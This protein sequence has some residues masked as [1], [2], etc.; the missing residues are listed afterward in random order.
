LKKTWMLLFFMAFLEFA[1][2]LSL[3]E[4]PGLIPPVYADPQD[5]PKTP[6]AEKIL[7]DRGLGTQEIP[8]RDGGKDK[9]YYSVTTPDEDRKNQ[10]EEKE[11]ADKS[12]EVLR[13]IIIDQRS[14]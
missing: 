1:A 8:R 13:N 10:E 7:P 5:P 3:E 9:V 12:W 2:S 14:R 4:K 11:K 6:E